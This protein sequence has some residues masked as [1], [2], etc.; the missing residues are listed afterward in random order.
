METKLEN[1]FKIPEMQYIPVMGMRTANA[2]T[3]KAKQ[4]DPAWCLR[5]QVLQS[6]REKGFRMVL[7]PGDIGFY[8]DEPESPM[9]KA[10][11]LTQ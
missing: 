6:T 4:E 9:A 5:Q 11:T 1:S 2:C 8:D 3:K 7:H 10:V